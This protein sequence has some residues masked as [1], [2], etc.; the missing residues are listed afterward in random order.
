LS[1]ISD[2]QARTT[3]GRV[4]RAR[5]ER[6]MSQRDLGLALGVS[7]WAIDRFETGVADATHHLAA[8]ANITGHVPEWFLPDE[9]GAPT[10]RRAA[11]YAARQDVD[12]GVAGR[13]LVL[14]AIVLL[15]TIRFFT[16]IVPVVPRAA[17]FVDIP[18]FL[19]LAVAALLVRGRS[20]T[21]RWYLEVGVP[22]VVFLALS[23]LSVVANSGRVA[24]APML[25]FIYGFLAPFAIYAA[26][27]RMWPHGSAL[28][29][30]RT[31][32]CLGVVELVVVAL[33]DV[34]RF[35]RSRDPDY[36]SGTFGTN[37]YQ[38]VFFLLIVVA[39]L[40][41]I[42]TVERTRAISRFVP[43]LV[44][45]SFATTLLAQY[46]SLLVG[47]AVAALAIGMLLGGRARG[48]AVVAFCVVGFATVF[49][50]VAAQLPALKL[51]SAVS[52][53]S[54]NPGAYASGRLGVARTVYRLYGDIP[55]AI[56]MGTGPGTFSS[57][58]WQ[59]F[60]NA[61]S[62]SQSNVAG[63]YATSLTGGKAYSTD[64][65]N[66]YV[67]PQLRFGAIV[68]GSHAVTQPYSSY[69]SLLAEVGVIGF[70]LICLVYFGALGRVWRMARA[71]LASPASD[72]P[73]PALVLATVIAFLTLVQL[74]LLE[75]WFEVT[76]VTFVAW[77]MLAVVTK[78]L[79]GRNVV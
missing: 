65:S 76:R 67:V 31:L 74:A 1:A 63:G 57:R 58:A 19:T 29:L 10:E 70:A 22:S 37:A 44:L 30:S 54:S 27:Y 40:I 39:L 14:G 68:Q 73:L 6:G 77:M 79:D 69:T 17:N 32:V 4:A 72:D 20:R 35:V 78:E 13:R 2:S 18:I 43:L 3:G 49:Y 36:V 23:A 12:L 9:P 61:T 42:A 11:A 60:A 38:L 46:R 51:N 75:N 52:S 15:V 33:V 45:A 62:Q 55:E 21:R 7:A 71:V 66:R 8:I 25:V 28:A 56:V 50:Y 5:A 64:V 53:L 47:T 41:G 48:I 16:E 24:I 26:T 59:T 34:P